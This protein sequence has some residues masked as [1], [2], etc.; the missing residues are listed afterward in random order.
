M[1]DVSSIVENYGA[2]WAEPD[3][4]KRRELLS[5]AWAEDGLYIDPSGRAEGREALVRHIAGFQKAFA[6]HRIDLTSGVAEHNGYISF[7]WKMLGPDDN[8]LMEG[9]DF[10]ELDGD[11]K[12]KKIVGFFGPWPDA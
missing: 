6:G 2:A 1:A 9:A 7:G 12:L 8:V 5:Q 10:G 4:D 3:D 11:G